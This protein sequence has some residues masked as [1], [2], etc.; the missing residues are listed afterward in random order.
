MPVELDLPKF[1]THETFY[2]KLG[3]NVK[4]WRTINMTLRS[5]R[6]VHVRSLNADRTSASTAKRTLLK[7]SVVVLVT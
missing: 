7:S 5:S 6:S 3:P 4:D 1:V 2:L